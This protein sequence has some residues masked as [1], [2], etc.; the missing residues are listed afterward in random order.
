M[1]STGVEDGVLLNELDLCHEVWRDHA[2]WRGI[3]LSARIVWLLRRG[4]EKDDGLGEYE[5]LR[6]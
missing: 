1:H 3:V 2:L 5:R 4:G 6:R